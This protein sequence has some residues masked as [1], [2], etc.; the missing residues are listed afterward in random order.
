MQNWKQFFIFLKKIIC[1]PLGA[2]KASYQNIGIK[3]PNRK[4]VTQ[5]IKN[6]TASFKN[7]HSSTVLHIFLFVCWLEGPSRTPK[8]IL[9]IINHQ[10]RW[11]I[12]YLFAISPQNLLWSILKFIIT[13][14]FLQIMS[15][16][17]NNV[18][19]LLIAAFRTVFL[20]TNIYSKDL[21]TN[22]IFTKNF[23]NF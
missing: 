4:Y 23:H 6:F 1:S 21:S 19:S 10:R 16:N 13:I 7:F 2:L 3:Y 22:F 9:Y 11:Q 15:T 18:G 8:K 5:V 17:V 12:N 14:N 20:I